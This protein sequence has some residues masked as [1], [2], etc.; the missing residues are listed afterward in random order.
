MWKSLI[1]KKSQIIFKN[2]SVPVCPIIASFCGSQFLN[3]LDI[4]IKK[5]FQDY[6]ILELFLWWR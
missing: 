1:L 3:F 4:K 5:K 2:F 6:Q